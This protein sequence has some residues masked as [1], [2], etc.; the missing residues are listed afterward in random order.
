MKMRFP[1]V[2][3]SFRDYKQGMFN[4]LEVTHRLPISDPRYCYPPSKNP[5]W[6]KLN[7]PSPLSFGVY[8]DNETENHRG[9]WRSQFQSQM[10]DSAHSPASQELHVEIGC[11]GGHVILEWAKRSP[12]KNFIGVDW[13]FKPIFRGAEKAAAKG[14]KNLIF[15]RAHAERI[16][17]M[18]GENEVDGL[19]LFFPDPWPRK[20]Q[21]KNRLIHE[22]RLREIAKIM[23]PS[24]IFHIK[25][26]HPGYF[27]WI[28][29]AVSNT[30]DVWETVDLTLNLHE[31]NPAPE[32]LKIPEVTLFESLF[33]RDQI[34]IQSL[35]LRP[36]KT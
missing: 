10:T 30:Q 17:F 18:L 6:T 7:S 14:L 2:S 29:E 19:Y 23:K 9:T 8:S 4:E 24:G 28:L 11:N 26:D 21:W 25:T 13:K 36:R 31:G 33:I 5:Y 1:L 15:L 35:K 27:Q 22:A 20:S 12:D 32:K 16:S 34:P 3:F